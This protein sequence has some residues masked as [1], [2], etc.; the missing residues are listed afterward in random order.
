MSKCSLDSLLKTTD[1]THRVTGGTGY[2]NGLYSAFSSYIG[3]DYVL[4]SEVRQS[5]EIFPLTY[6]NGE[7]SMDVPNTDTG[8]ILLPIIPSKISVVEFEVKLIQPAVITSTPEFQIML[9]SNQ[10][11]YTRVV[12]RVNP[13]YS[14]EWEKIEV[15]IDNPVDVY[16]IGL[17]TTVSWEIKNFNVY[18]A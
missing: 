11:S 3:T 10:L 15:Q 5:Y 12:N 9:E 8:W 17:E 18:V 16:Y 7:L 4:W 6:N 14:G 1:M 13:T 2:H